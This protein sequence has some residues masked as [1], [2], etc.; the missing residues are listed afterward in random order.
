[1]P[2]SRVVGTML[3]KENRP[4]FHTSPTSS[5]ISD[6][7]FQNKASLTYSF[8]NS[9]RSITIEGELTPLSPSELD[10]DW[11]KYDQDFR[12]HY[13][14]FGKISGEPLQSPNDLTQERD[15]LKPEDSLARPE[16]FIG[17]KFATIN[18]VCFYSVKE[19]EFAVSTLYER[20]DETADW[21]RVSL[22]P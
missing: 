12:T 19:A 15:S 2:R 7:K 13:M 20:E 5:K 21:T 16:S 10:G 4:K 11:L 18:R 8:Q 9:L 22:V 1:M 6:I 17:Y 3:D 14:V